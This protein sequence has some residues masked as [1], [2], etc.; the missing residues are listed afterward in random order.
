[1][2]LCPTGHV[3]ATQL[4]RKRRCPTDARYCPMLS[5]VSRPVF[6]PCYRRLRWR[7]AP[8]TWVAPAFSAVVTRASCA[9]LQG[10]ASLAVAGPAARGILIETFPG[11]LRRASTVLALDCGNGDVEVLVLDPLVFGVGRRG[12]VHGMTGSEYLWDD[13]YRPSRCCSGP[14]RRSNQDCQKEKAQ[15]QRVAVVLMIAGIHELADGGHGA[16]VLE[17]REGGLHPLGRGR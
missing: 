11:A 17:R 16:A 7:I 9:R 14:L 6:G 5:H 12:R 10:R 4:V 15:D 3:C 2:L 1:M 13:V 8:T